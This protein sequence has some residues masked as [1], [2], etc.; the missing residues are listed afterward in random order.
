MKKLIPLILIL[1]SISN[2]NAQQKFY[3][4]ADAGIKWMLP[5][6]VSQGILSSSNQTSMVYG[7]KVGYQFTKVLGIESGFY[8]NKFINNYQVTYSGEFSD[9]SASTFSDGN[10]EFVSI[11][12][13]VKLRQVFLN[14]KIAVN[15]FFGP[16]LY[17]S[18]LDG[19]YYSSTNESHSG[20]VVIDVVVNAT[21]DQK[22][23]PLFSGGLGLDFKIISNLWFVSSFSTSVGGKTMNTL[24]VDW[25][26]QSAD[27]ESDNLTTK[28]KGDSFD[29][30]FG[31]KYNFGK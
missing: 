1:I 2:L 10:M 9:Y 29:L 20:D 25:Q 23:T 22:F 13:H 18:N 6:Y 15:T 17:I 12:L 21:R 11:P 5:Q 4:Q 24:N 8:S 31:L 3:L 14:D 16:E 26:P 27:A 30:K 7:M 28:W 19:E